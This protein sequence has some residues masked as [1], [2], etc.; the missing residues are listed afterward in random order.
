MGHAKGLS[1]ADQ[2]EACPPGAW[3]SAGIA[4]P[5]PRDSYNNQT[6]QDNQGACERCPLHATS[7]SHSSSAEACRCEDGYVERKAQCVLCPLPGTTC[8]SVG[9]TLE[10]LPLAHG[11]WRPDNSS[12]NVRPCLDRAAGS[13]SGC[14]GGVPLCKADL[15]LTGVYC[16]TCV[17]DDA[18]YDDAEC[19]SC[20]VLVE[21]WTMIIVCTVAGLVLLLLFGAFFFRLRC[22]RS[23]LQPPQALAGRLTRALARFHPTSKLKQAWGFCQIVGRMGAVYQLTALPDDVERIRSSFEAVISLG[24]AGLGSLLH[25]VGLYSEENEL[26][27]WVVVPLL[28]IFIIGTIPLARA[29]RRRRGR[30]SWARQALLWSL[31]PTLVIAFGSYPI[32]ASVAF[33]AFVCEPL[34]D[35]SLVRFLPPSYSLECGPKDTPTAEYQH[36]LDV[37]AGA[38]VLYP[39]GISLC[40]ALLL[41]VAREPLRTGR[42]TEFT[43]AIA[44]LHQ[45]YEPCFF[46]WELVE[47]LK[48]LLLIGFAVFVQV[49]SVSQLVFGLSITLLH[50]ILHVELRPNLHASD[51]R[52]ATVFSFAL[53]VFFSCLLV[54][55]TQIL[56]D[57][58]HSSLSDYFQSLFDSNTVLLSFA[59]IASLVGGLFVSLLAFLLHLT[60][61]RRKPYLRWSHGER[62]TPTVLAGGRY[63]TFLSQCAASARP[64][65][66]LHALCT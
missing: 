48:K 51:D 40:T 37:A 15:N 4:I 49:G 5:C 31:R 46:W 45:E 35:M 11:Y 44:F 60:H 30:A 18:Y 42:S 62:V 22:M 21:D 24:F 29:A 27:F 2:C 39:V 41:F 33:Q 63:H 13:A 53:V 23:R 54:L 43:R 47:Q 10:H 12:L 52:V 64:N 28:L 59:M 7:P 32:V 1:R 66:R 16:R 25:C 20:D 14:G 17:D 6:N 26:I 8:A 55:K 65:S 61:E 34:D 3:C 9:I 36:L 56:V 50:F 38:I 57:A 19:H 58:V